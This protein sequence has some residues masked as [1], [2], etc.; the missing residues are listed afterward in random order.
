MNSDASRLLKLAEFWEKTS[1]RGTKY[2]SAYMG[3]VQLLL[4]RSG[5]KDHPTKPGERVVVWR[6]MAQ[7]RDP[8]R[9]PKSASD[10]AAAGRQQVRAIPRCWGFPTRGRAT[11]STS[12]QGAAN[13]QPFDD[14]EAAVDDLT[15]AYD[16]R[17][18]R[19]E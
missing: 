1:Q 5:E 13:N 8:A 6:L 4:F 7:E 15:R 11:P 16:E 2:F 18:R 3:D 12:P 17:L 9:R 10:S 14:S 19:G